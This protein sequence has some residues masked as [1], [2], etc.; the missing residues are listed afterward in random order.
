[1]IIRNEQPGDASALHNVHCA[2]F[3]TDAEARL[4]DRLRAN[5]H[6]PISLV[7]EIDGLVVGH[8]LFSPV[9]ID[10]NPEVAGGLGLAPVAVLPAW[11]RQG[12][13]SRL[14]EAGLAACRKQGF[15]FVVVLGHV[16]YYPKFGFQKASLFGL[17]NEYGVDDEFMVL[18]LQPGS[19]PGQGGPGQIRPGVFGVGRLIDAGSQAL[20]GNPVGPASACC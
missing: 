13:G 15:R 5:S 14:I 17:D 8:I 9:S 1:M 2:A 6:G 3:P 4:V 18:Q 7:A 11:Q 20:P 10:G 19:L 12:V 16:A